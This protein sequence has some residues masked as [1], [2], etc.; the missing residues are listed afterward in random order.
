MY[1]Y[2]IRGWGKLNEIIRI[3]AIDYLLVFALTGLVWIGLWV[4]KKINP[5]LNFSS[6]KSEIAQ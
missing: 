2:S 5:K 4:A 6:T 3:P 1:V